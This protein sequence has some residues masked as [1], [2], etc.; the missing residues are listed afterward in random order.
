MRPWGIIDWLEIIAL[1]DG[2][3]FLVLA[4]LVGLLFRQHDESVLNELQKLRKV[5]E[6][7]K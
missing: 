7:T 4:V 5:V 3:G 1:I 6:G 2:F